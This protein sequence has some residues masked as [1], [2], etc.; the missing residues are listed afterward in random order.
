MVDTVGTF[1]QFGKAH[2]GARFSNDQSSFSVTSP[3]EVS[4]SRRQDRGYD[5]AS[6]ASDMLVAEDLRVCSGQEAA[7]A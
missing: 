3:D 5:E 6:N 2:G 4:A 7:G 1:A